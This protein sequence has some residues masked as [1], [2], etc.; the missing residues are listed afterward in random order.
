MTVKLYYLRDSDGNPS[1][2]TAPL[3]KL[4][5]FSQGYSSQCGADWYRFGGSHTCKNAMNLL[6]SAINLDNLPE[7]S[8]RHDIIE[9]V[10]SVNYSNYYI[11]DEAENSSD[12]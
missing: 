2:T 8:G 6:V 12:K 4:K 10:L 11:L 5:K 7:L 9:I 3:D 1:I